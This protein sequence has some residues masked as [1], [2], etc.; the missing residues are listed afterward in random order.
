MFRH[1][2][3]ASWAKHSVSL[4]TLDYEQHVLELV[5]KSGEPG[6][7]TPASP[8]TTIATTAMQSERQ[9]RNP[10]KEYLQHGAGSVE[11]LGDQAPL[12][13]HGDAIDAG[14]RRLHCRRATD[15]WD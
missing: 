12:H 3:S 8:P 6:Q 9:S 15:F 7:T 1:G 4:R 2:S 10:K 13:D 5:A 14:A 11:A